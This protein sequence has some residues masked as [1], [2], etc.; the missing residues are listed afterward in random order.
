MLI[1]RTTRS[2][3]LTE[4]GR[5]IFDRASAILADVEMTLDAARQFTRPEGVLHMTGSIAFGSG[6][7]ADLISRYLMQYPKVDVRVSLEDRIVNL[8]EEEIDVALRI[9]AGTQWNLPARRLAPIRW[10]YCAAPSYLQEHGGTTDPR[11]VAGREC[12]VYPAMTQNGG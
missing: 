6:R 1:M 12:L 9:T 3:K 5:V 8:A 4:H 2:L 10:V 11:D 7:L